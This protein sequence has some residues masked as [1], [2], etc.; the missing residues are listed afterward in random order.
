MHLDTL[1][2]S[3]FI[4]AGTLLHRLKDPKASVNWQKVSA[5]AAAKHAE[6][7]EKEAAGDE[8]RVE[9]ELN[10]K[11]LCCIDMLLY[12]DVPKEEGGAGEG[13]DEFGDNQED[14][15]LGDADE[16]SLDELG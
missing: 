14:E 6:A 3:N 10:E 2:C 12:T 5:A 4:P 13:L 9:G 11:T 7:A 8:K 15:E 1:K 16:D